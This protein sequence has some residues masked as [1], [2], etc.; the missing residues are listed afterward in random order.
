MP[1]KSDT[2]RRYFNANR[3]ELE[4]QGVDVD[5]WNDSS[6]GKKLPEKVNKE[7]N[8]AL[9]LLHRQ[10]SQLLSKLADDESDDKPAKK[11]PSESK[12]I[13]NMD[14]TGGAL[15][16]YLSPLHWGGERAGRTQAMADAIDEKTTF[17]VRHPYLQTAG[18]S[19]IGGGLGGLLGAGAGSLLDRSGEGVG[20]G[21]GVG[22]LLGAI[23]GQLNAGRV[24]RNEMKRIGHFYDEDFAAGKVNP[25]NPKLSALSALL[26]PLRGAHRSGQVEAVKSMR[27]EQTIPEQRGAAR[28]ALYVGSNLPYVGVPLALLHGYGQN[29]KT[30]LGSKDT[31][32]QPVN[33][34]RRPRLKAASTVELLAR[35]LAKQARCWEGYEPVPG[36]APYSEDS[37]RPA[38]SGKKKKEKKA[39]IQDIFDRLTTGAKQ[40]GQA[41]QN[42]RINYGP[43]SEAKAMGTAGGAVLGSLAGAGAG[44]GIYGLRRLFSNKDDEKKPSFLNHLAAGAGIGGLAGG[45]GMLGMAHGHSVGAARQR[46]LDDYTNII[47]P[48][49]YAKFVDQIKNNR[50]LR[51]GY[52]LPEKQSAEACS[53]GCGKPDGECGCN[54]SSPVQKLARLAVK[55]EWN[56]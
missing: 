29:I 10:A 15:A 27:G 25:K 18:H 19:L 49:E 7:A 54:D 48:N 2:Q 4:S 36:K 5:E 38:G 41:I 50:F 33:F 8:D 21:A 39:G 11:K 51:M 52:R 16:D 24:R 40:V 55:Q 32:S 43:S 14:S 37:C 20:V 26:L 13:V 22:A 31:A 42:P 12:K 9:N 3:K 53:C 6:R 34:E 45:T 28:N 35:G 30:Q 46:N 23:A 1:Y 56:C 47:S 17:G 44:A